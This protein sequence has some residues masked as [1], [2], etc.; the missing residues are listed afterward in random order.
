MLKAAFFYLKGKQFFTKQKGILCLAGKPVD[1]AKDL[2]KQG[3][4]LLHIIDMDASGGNSPNFDVYD[5]LTQFINIQVEC[6]N[7]EFARKLI[8]MKSRI[9]VT[10][11]TDFDLKQFSENKRLIVGKIDS[12]E[13]ISEDVYD[14]IIENADDK[15]VESLKTKKRIIVYEKDYEKLNNKNKRLVWAVLEN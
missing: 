3:Y 14:L 1:V 15:L 4:K 12:Y 11:P 2:S 5:V 6:K 8:A 7:K 10:F 9:V 13:K